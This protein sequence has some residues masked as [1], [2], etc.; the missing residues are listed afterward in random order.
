[1]NNE[2]APYACWISKIVASESPVATTT[3]IAHWIMK[4][5]HMLA[6]SPFYFEAN[7]WLKW[8]LFTK[9]EKRKKRKKKLLL[10]T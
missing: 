10:F 7:W 2:D 3:R 6:E 9:K 1:L 8:V 5:H 4:M